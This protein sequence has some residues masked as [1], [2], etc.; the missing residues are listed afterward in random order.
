LRVITQNNRP[1]IQLLNE[2]NEVL[3]TINFV[4]L[5]LI[6]L[7]AP[8]YTVELIDDEDFGKFVGGYIVSRNGELV[9]MVAPTGEIFTEK[10]LTGAY[11]YDEERQT[12]T[13]LLRES[14]LSSDIIEVEIKIQPF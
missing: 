4:S 14:A 3:F 5:E 9:M 8:A 11:K 2:R 7:I 6:R 10:K 12:V 1:V 13:Y